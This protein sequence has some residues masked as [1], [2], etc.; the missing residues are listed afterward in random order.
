MGSHGPTWAEKFRS[1]P[2]SYHGR[3][4][5]SSSYLLPHR[6]LKLG[7]VPGPTKL[8]ET[9]LLSFTS[10]LGT[11]HMAPSHPGTHFLLTVSSI[12]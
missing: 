2:I 10:C 6:H 9:T 11:N 5:L 3:V 8:L 12:A 1:E 7:Q 4:L